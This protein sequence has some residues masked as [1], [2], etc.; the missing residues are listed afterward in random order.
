MTSVP[1][2]DNLV[3]FQ[4]LVIKEIHRVTRIWMQTV[5]PPAIT[6]TLYFIIFGSL[7]GSRIGTMSGFSY[8]EYLAPGL[9]M[10]AV[11]MNSYSNV[12]SSFF[13]AKF[14]RH[15]EELM[16]SP[17]P[18]ILILLGYMA[19]GIFRGLMV[20]ILVAIVAT[21]FTHLPLSHPLVMVTV[22]MMTSGVFSM[23]GLINAIFAKSFDDISIVPTF[24]LTPLI[25][26]GGVFYSIDL[27]SPTWKIVSKIDPILYMVNAFRYGF[28]GISDISIGVAYAI[29]GAFLVILFT[30]ALILLNRGIGLRS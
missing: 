2:K 18:N 23:G 20:G 5:V 27:L 25:Y 8:M 11:V 24:V 1:I 13:G 7:I 12:V 15:I 9:I 10:M 28:L 21:F 30:T 16:V 14:S 4:T 6:M 17:M 26:L 3:G 29:I 22:V 19:G